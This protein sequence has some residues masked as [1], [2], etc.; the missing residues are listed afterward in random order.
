[1]YYIFLEWR[2]SKLY[3]YLMNFKSGSDITN[4]HVYYMAGQYCAVRLN[5]FIVISVL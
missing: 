3:M 1:M 4:M 2:L 5:S